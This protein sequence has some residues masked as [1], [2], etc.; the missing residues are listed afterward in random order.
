MAVRRLAAEQPETFAFSEENSAWANAQIAKY[1]EGRQAS[2]VIPILWR[3]QEQEGWVSEPTIRYVA[4]M[5]DMAFIRVLEVATFYT[6]FQ[7]SPVGSAAHIQVCGTT[8]CMLR[9]SDDIIAVCKQRISQTPHTLSADGKFSW[10]EV[11]CLGA[12]VNA[13]MVQ[14]V[15]DTYED[16]TAESFEALLDTW[17][18]GETPTPGP[19]NG[20][21]YA[22]P[23]GGMTSLTDPGLYDGTIARDMRMP[24]G[25]TE[26]DDAV[27]TPSAP[28]PEQ[29]APSKESDTKPK[30][31]KSSSPKSAVPEIEEDG[32]GDALVEALP[33]EAFEKDEEAAIAAALAAVGAEASD[34][35]KAD[36]V[37][38]R[39][40][41]LEA[42]RDNRADDL[43]KIKGIGKVNEDKLNGMGIFHYDQIADWKRPEIRWAGQY[44]SFAGRIDR[45]DWVGQARG[46]SGK[47]T[48]SSP[49]AAGLVS[50]ASDASEK[51]A[52]SA[53][54]SRSKE[55]SDPAAAKGLDDAERP[56][57]LAK[58]DGGKADDLKQIKGVGPKIETTLNSLGIFHFHQ[59]AVWN[60]DNKDWIDGYLRFKGR[61]DREDWVNQAKL[62]ASGGETD[63]SKRV[64]AGDVPSSK[65]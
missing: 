25:S 6:M 41:G 10:E 17:D 21:T 29:A 63:F 64:E 56:A 33:P 12:C 49:P 59:I 8:P 11:E 13:P 27:S 35:A 47:Q 9:G 22:A 42:A 28:A 48:I 61:I 20:R 23:A 24:L 2:A 62:L 31:S 52:V 46:L 55:T 65:T 40:P 30:A 3:A 4:E 58:P 45:E 1:P 54:P 34:E 7:L 16:L 57:S 14:M 44:L 26:G 60:D 43:K 15:K 32:A 5:L 39:P 18:R 37:G 38:T 19:Q 50:A 36:A 51:P 53:K